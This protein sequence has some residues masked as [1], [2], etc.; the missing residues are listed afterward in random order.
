M[1]HESWTA[2]GLTGA[3]K[4]RFPDGL[5]LGFTGVGTG[6]AAGVGSGV[7]TVGGVG[8]GVFTGVGVGP[9]PGVGVG[10][11]G[12]EGVVT[13]AVL[14]GGPSMLRCSGVFI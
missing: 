3:P 1:I 11:K 12:P 13:E 4:R 10:V 2:V 7:G 5:S 14:E 8:V 9:G 6:V